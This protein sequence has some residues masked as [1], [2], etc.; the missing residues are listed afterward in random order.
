MSIN[1]G[2]SIPVVM[3]IGWVNKMREDKDHQMMTSTMI[4]LVEGNVTIMTIIIS[5][6]INFIMI[7]IRN[8]ACHPH[9]FI[10]DRRTLS[11]IAPFP[12]YYTKIL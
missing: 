11:S 1:S 6:F 3:W 4:M 8:I 10:T 5:V 9:E 12:K 7:A 2:T